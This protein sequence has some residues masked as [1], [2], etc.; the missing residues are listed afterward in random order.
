MADIGVDECFG[1][2]R[3]VLT[4]VDKISQRHGF[5][6]G[7]C[8]GSA[9]A[10]FGRSRGLRGGRWL[11]GSGCLRRGRGTCRQKQTQQAQ[12]AEQAY[13]NRW[14]FFMISSEIISKR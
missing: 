14:F 6:S 13:S 11:G 10:G 2:I 1:R 12:N 9:A 4:I 3:A 8:A 5:G 7:A